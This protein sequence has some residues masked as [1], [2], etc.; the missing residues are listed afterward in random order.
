MSSSTVNDL[1]ERRGTNVLYHRELHTQECPCRTPEGFRDPAWHKAHPTAPE[2]NSAGYLSDPVEA[3]VKAFVQPVMAGRRSIAM[4]SI[5]EMFGQ[6]QTDDHIGVFPVEWAGTQLEF[7]N[8]S[9]AGDEYIEYNTWRF[10]V[11]GWSAV[12]SPANAGII[13]HYETALRRINK[14]PFGR[15]PSGGW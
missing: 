5:T 4:Q 11:V 10:V 13:H 15:P 9:Q 1:L 7:D 8:W 3:T 14:I 12:P 2:C 6:V